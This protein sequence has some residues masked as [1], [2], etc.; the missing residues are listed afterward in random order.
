MLDTTST[1]PIPRGGSLGSTTQDIPRG[2]TTL[3]CLTVVH[4]PDPQIIGK[5]LMVRPG[6]R[7]TIGRGDELLGAGALDD[8]RISR[9]HCQVTLEATTLM[10]RDMD[11]LNGTFVNDRRTLERPL[12]E[13][14]L[15]SVGPV[16]FLRHDT[17]PAGPRKHPYLVGGSPTLQRVIESIR[18]VAPYRT[19]ALILGESGTGKELVARS[20]HD[21]SGRKGPLLMVNCGGMPDGLLHS[22]LFG[23][24]KGAFSGA[25]TERQGLIEAANSG[26]LFLD[27]VGDASANLQ[28]S[29][30]RFL[31]EGEVRRVGTNRTRRVDT[32]VI[33]ATNRDLPA[34][35]AAGEFR[36]DLYARLS[37]WVI[38]VPPLR[39]RKEDI[40][41][42]VKH[43][44]ARTGGPKRISRRLVEAMLQYSWPRNVRELE[45]VVK[46]AVIESRGTGRLRLTPPIEDALSEAPVKRRQGTAREAT[47]R[48]RMSA[49]PDADEL[50]R[51]LE[52]ARGNVRRVAQDLGV[53]RT[54]AYRWI[55][56]MNLDLDAIRRS[57]GRGRVRTALSLDES[58]SPVHATEFS[59]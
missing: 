22:E 9:N 58:T 55:K 42:L 10:V 37:G 29:L 16:L 35:V 51:L 1:Q 54:T 27:E 34:M 39:D 19:T 31:Q 24:A 50:Y 49:P 15:L 52:E 26:T 47:V 13:G 33:A 20:I 44:S 56:E 17:V 4:H 41:A 43:F 25:N 59:G 57:T 2:L 38:S 53:A 11:S 28:A 14:D 30:L 6:G 8:V 40:P 48:K 45:G 36:E 7:L 23:H 21:Q 46:R 32:R 12:D 3:P 18:A 5:S